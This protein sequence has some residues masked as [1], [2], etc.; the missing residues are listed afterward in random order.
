MVYNLYKG[1]IKGDMKKLEFGTKEIIATVTATILYVLFEGIQLSAVNSGGVP[2][3]LYDYFKLRVLVTFLVAAMFG[4]IVGVIV[5]VGA[6]ML[7]TVAF[8]GD[9]SI[10]EVA[11]YIICAL[12]TGWYYDKYKVLEGGFTR[13]NIIVFNVIQL[14]MNVFCSL[15]FVPLLFF[16]FYKHDL[17]TDLVKGVESAVGSIAL[18]GLV[19]TGI[20]YVAS[21]IVR[22]SKKRNVKTL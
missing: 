7:V 18:V 17:L 13:Q 16:V 21:T 20:M 11:V 12:V 10:V 22:K 5:A 14:M 15:L 6:T 1:K 19:G 3:V 9:V 8:H 4:P 2:A